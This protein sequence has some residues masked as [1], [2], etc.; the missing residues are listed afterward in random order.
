MPP[1][2][3]LEDLSRHMLAHHYGKRTVE[4]YVY[5]V[6]FYIRF[7]NKRHPRDLG[8]RDVMAFLTFLANERQ[9]SISTQ[10]I[11][12]NALAYLYNKYLLKPLGALGIFNKATRPRKLPVVLTRSEV[13]SLL[14]RLSGSRWLLA[15]MIYAS[16]LRRIGR[17]IARQRH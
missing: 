9:V 11:A 1:S 13:A 16:G 5:W 17:H 7:H 14:A 15:S 10:K 6:R 12:L 3:F 2:P 8:A 4:S